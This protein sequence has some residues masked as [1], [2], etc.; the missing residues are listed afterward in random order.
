V[1]SR[2]RLRVYIEP[3]LRLFDA[4]LRLRL[5]LLLDLRLRFEARYDLSGVLLVRRLHELTQLGHARLD[6]GIRRTHSNL[7]AL[8]VWGVHRDGPRY[9]RGTALEERRPSPVGARRQRHNDPEKLLCV[10]VD[11]LHLSLPHGDLRLIVQ[12]RSMLT[13]RPDR[14]AS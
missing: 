5:R 11:A 14:T 12:S 13:V 2:T 10:G 1:R 8:Q 6:L 7:A 9:A 3:A 4:A